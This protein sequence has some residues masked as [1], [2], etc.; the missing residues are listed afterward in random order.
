MSYGS[1][2]DATVKGLLPN[3]GQRDIRDINADYSN[4]TLVIGCEGLRNSDDES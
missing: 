3:K 1:T 4:L 2:D